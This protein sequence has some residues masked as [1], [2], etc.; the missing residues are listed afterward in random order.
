MMDAELYM[1]AV[2]AAFKD[3]GYR[4]AETFIEG[5]HALERPDYVI[6]LNLDGSIVDLIWDAQAWSV[7]VHPYPHAV[8]NSE[9][10]RQ[11]CD[12]NRAAPGGVVRLAKPIIGEVLRRWGPTDWTYRSGDGWQRYERRYGG[13]VT[14][15][16]Y[17]VA[18][19]LYSGGIDRAIGCGLSL[20]TNYGFPLGHVSA[21]Q[22]VDEMY[23]THIASPSPYSMVGPT[24]L[25]DSVRLR[26]A[27]LA[28]R[29]RKEQYLARL[30]R[31]TVAADAER[32]TFAELKELAGW[33]REG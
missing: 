9:L 20:G 23:E 24:A 18:A 2:V 21:Q 14:G 15:R 12:D 5:Y 26:H 17:T 10:S 11:L 28:N 7:I 3:A 30:A 4:V 8:A 25:A 27:D 16:V 13:G 32:L 19:G 22:A 1:D 6:R 33:K 29:H 31:E